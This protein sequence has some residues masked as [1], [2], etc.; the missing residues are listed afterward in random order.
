MCQAY[1]HSCSPIGTGRRLLRR[2]ITT[3]GSSDKTSHLIVVSPGGVL[4]PRRAYDLR[5]AEPRQSQLG[6]D[7]TRRRS[8]AKSIL[9]QEFAR[10][11]VGREHPDQSPCCD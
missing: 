9:K 7:I 10:T 3:H 11:V 2:S 1:C 4:F 5:E 8:D 6:H